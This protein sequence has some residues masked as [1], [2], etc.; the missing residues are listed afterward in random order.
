[1]IIKEIEI[2][3]ALIVLNK[4]INFFLLVL[5]LVLKKISIFSFNFSSQQ[6]QKIKKLKKKSKSTTILKK[7]LNCN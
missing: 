4:I 1:M 6:L 3:V 5:K 7:A 2:E